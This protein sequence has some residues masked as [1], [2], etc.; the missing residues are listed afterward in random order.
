MEHDGDTKA[1][2]LRTN[3]TLNPHPE[4]VRESV[5]L[6]NPFFDPR[7]LLQVRYEM[8]RRVVVEHHGIARTAKDFGV[9][10]PTVYHIQKRF[11]EGGISSLVNLRSGPKG[12]RK[13]RGDVLQFISELL[14]TEGRLPYRELSRRVEAR[15]GISV[16]PS[17]IFRALRAWGKKRRSARLRRPKSRSP[18]K[19]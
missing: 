14:S 11:R 2:I 17:T 16:D 19:R 9:S 7:D 15:F 1:G 12:S 18:R 4:R 10:R 3:R 13:I 6:T 8:A 5:F